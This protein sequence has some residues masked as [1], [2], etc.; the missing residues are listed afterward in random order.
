MTTEP[1]D[2]WKHHARQWSLVRGPLRP[3]KEDIGRAR[4]AIERWSEEAV[5]K[6]PP[7]VLVLGATPELC[8]LGVELGSRVIAVDN[9]ADMLRT[10]WPVEARDTDSTICADWREIPLPAKSVDV[11]LAD[12][13]LSALSFPQDYESLLS[14]LRR[15]L[16]PGGCCSIRCFVQPDQNETI[17]QVFEAL[18]RGDIGNFHV[19]KWRLAMALQPDAGAGVAVGSVW[20]AFS[21]AW[22]DPSLL[23]DRF[24]WPLAEVRTIE[25][26]RNV[27]TRYT[28]PTLAQYHESFETAGFHVVE[29]ATP[30]YE[31]GERCPSFIL[32]PVDGSAG[33]S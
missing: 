18:S 12:G 27:D 1:I 16:R 4:F 11:V 31:L 2:H 9:S 19:L 25:A 6:T 28:F 13:S 24:Q 10:L 14:E 30:S 29:T 8:R 22:E 17:E 33:R 21:R 3:R 7:V 32:A 20:Q 26:Y 5:Q 23:A 15:L